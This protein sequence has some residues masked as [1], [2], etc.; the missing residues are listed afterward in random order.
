MLLGVSSSI[1]VQT[2]EMGFIGQLSTEHVAALTFTFPISMVLTSIAL[3]V[4][5]GT[6]SVIARGAGAGDRH[7]MRRLGTHSILLMGGLMSLLA[8]A[9]WMVIDPLFLAMGASPEMLPLIHSYLDIYYPGTVLFT[10]TMIT[11]SIMRASGNATVPGF[12]MTAG[13]LVHLA[14]DPFLIFGWL[15]LPRMELAGAATAMTGVRILTAAVL[16]R[17]V[18][19]DGLI[20]TSAVFCGFADSAAR[21]LKI[22]VPAAATQIIA[23]LSNALITRLVAAHGETAVAGFGVATRVEAV[24]A[25]SLFALSGSV[26]PFV[27]QNWGANHFDRVRAGVRAAYRFS[28]AWGLGAAVAMALWGGDIAAWVNPDAAVVAVAALYLLIVPISYGPW[29]VLMMASAS[30]NALGKP[31]PSTVLSFTRM[32][33]VYVPLAILLNHH[34][35]YAGIFVATALSNLVMGLAGFLWLQRRFL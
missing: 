26:G 25:M 23:P 7:D 22:A 19:R 8:L 14:I 27:G 2:I 30:F 4:G 33:V 5:I 31:V 17:A 20:D 9:G 34:Y 24:A 6:S 28:L 10:L 3:G 13:A 21:I 11:A 35:G 12:V 1:L 16:L 29:G 15:G 18:H 32:F